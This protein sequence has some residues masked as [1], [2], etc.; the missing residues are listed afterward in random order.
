MG[1][2]KETVRLSGERDEERQRTAITITNQWGAVVAVAMHVV[3]VVEVA[4]APGHVVS[5]VSRNRADVRVNLV[6][7][8]VQWVLYSTSAV[9]KHVF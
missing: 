2:L 4:S 8:K 3:Q 1:T 6:E 9:L 5:I 7:D